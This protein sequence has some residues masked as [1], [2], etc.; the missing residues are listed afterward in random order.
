MNKTILRQEIRHTTLRVLYKYYPSAVPDYS[1]FIE[2]HWHEEFEIN[3]IRSGTAR[4]EYDNCFYTA[5]EGD[6]FIFCPN[7]IH[8]INPLEKSSAYYDTLLFKGDIFGNKNERGVQEY[9]DCLVEGTSEI[10]MPIN[11]HQPEYEK[12]EEIIEQIF[13]S[14][15]AALGIEDMLLKGKL[16]EL[17]YLLH[18]NDCIRKNESIMTNYVELVEPALCYMNEHFADKVTVDELAELV[19]LSKSY[20]MSCFKKATGLGAIN[21]LEQIRIKNV[22][23][24]L[25]TTDLSVVEIASKCGFNNLSNF[26]RIFKKKMVY[27]PCDYRKMYSNKY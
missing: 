21:Y 12:L 24:Q 7:R 6:I 17:F 16:L 14:A 11:I 4:F 15:K 2:P 23:N 3:Y 18:K 26:N 5:S 22:C 13:M 19:S 20:F 27:S 1:P 8:A 9:I 25:I 10:K